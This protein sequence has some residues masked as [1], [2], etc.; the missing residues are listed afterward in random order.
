MGAVCC[1]IGEP[2]GDQGQLGWREGDEVETC[3][4]AVVGT[5]AGR[6]VAWGEEAHGARTGCRLERPEGQA[7]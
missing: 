7:L 2:E 1:V 4:Q 3:R 5:E 6:V